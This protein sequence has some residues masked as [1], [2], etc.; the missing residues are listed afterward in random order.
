MSKVRRLPQ[1]QLKEV[2]WTKATEQAKMG[3]R[4]ESAMW[5]H[6]TRSMQTEVFKRETGKRL[7]GRDTGPRELLY[8]KAY[9]TKLHVIEQMPETARLLLGRNKLRGYSLEMIWAN[10]T[11]VVSQGNNAEVL[12]LSINRMFNL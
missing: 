12:L 6:K 1:R 11:A 2:G 3:E 10:F 8:F 4:S 5:L 7:T 9:K